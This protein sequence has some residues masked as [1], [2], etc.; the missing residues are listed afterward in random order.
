MPQPITNI[1][2]DFS[3]E[4]GLAPSSI[5]DRTNTA[6]FKKIDLRKVLNISF[7]G[8]FFDFIENDAAI[9]ELIADFAA[10][11]RKLEAKGV[12]VFTRKP[13]GSGFNVELRVAAMASVTDFLQG[14]RVKTAALESVGGLEHW[15][16]FSVLSLSSTALVGS[17]HEIIDDR[18]GFARY[19]LDRFPQLDDHFND[20]ELSRVDPIP[21]IA[22]ELKKSRTFY[23]K[24]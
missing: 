15:G 2:E 11:V 13:I 19:C 22:Q 8:S 1:I 17:F 20:T 6:I 14:Q 4:V 12:R 7:S 5:D 23:L 10:F 21:L 3:Q 24:W 9:D 18:K 16:K